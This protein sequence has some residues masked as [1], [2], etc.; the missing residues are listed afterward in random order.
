[1]ME[2]LYTSP[3]YG[4]CKHYDSIRS[5]GNNP[6]HTS[7]FLIVGY[8]IDEKSLSSNLP[9][10]V[11]F[12]EETKF[13]TAWQH[14]LESRGV[15]IR[16]STE[17]DEVLE[18]GKKG[19]KVLTR[20]RRPQPDNHNPNAAD[21]DLPQTLEEYDEIVL[22]V[23]ADTAQRLLGKTSRWI[24]RQVLG[25]TKW[26]DDITVTHNVSHLYR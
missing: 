10:M 4:M 11:V 16:L 7:C 9:P 1:M 23:L 24:D 2:R 6:T 25:S 20:P 18:R 8:E 5:K 21:Q 19:V 3:T 26:A 15:K 22:C 14:A 17:V 13:Y 12:P